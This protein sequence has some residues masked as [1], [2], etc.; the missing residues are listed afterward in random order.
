MNQSNESLEN[1]ARQLTKVHRITWTIIAEVLF[2][3]AFFGKP[4]C[5]F[6]AGI[7]FLFS[8][9]H[10]HYSQR[11]GNIVDGINDFW[12][13]AKEYNSNNNQ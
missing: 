11:H 9:A 7:A 8:R 1:T 2:I 3:L 12:D 4:A 10:W 13:E 5:L 6:A